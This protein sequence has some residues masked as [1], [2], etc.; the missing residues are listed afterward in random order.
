M[1]K[2]KNFTVNEAKKQIV[3][4]NYSELTDAETREIK[5]RTELGGYT[6][7]DRPKRKA[8][9]FSKLKKAQIP[10]IIAGNKEA[11]AFY[12][13]KESL[14]I[15]SLKKAMKDKYP[16]LFTTEAINKALKK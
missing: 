8:S 2:R 4:N 12:K 16:D 15:M 13:E 9:A 11:E 14:P 10:S 3:I 6:I 1:A 7:V 5:N